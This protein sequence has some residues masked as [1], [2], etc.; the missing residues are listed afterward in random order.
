MQST[1][2]QSHRLYRHSPSRPC[3]RP[4]RAL[5]HASRSAPQPPASASQWRRLT[6]AHYSRLLLS[7]RS[8]R[9]TP[10][11]ARGACLSAV[12]TPCRCTSASCR[13]RFCCDTAQ[14]SRP[15][16]RS[17]CSYCRYFRC[18]LHHRTL[19]RFTHSLQHEHSP[20]WKQLKLNPTQ[21]AH[22]RC[23]PWLHQ[24]GFMPPPML[25]YPPSVRLHHS[26]LLRSNSPA[27]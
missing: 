25:S 12:T 13:V 27:F 10:T 7:P 22:E 5:P 11:P 4:C 17:Q 9:S 8:A 6:T 18:P 14:D 15:C 23:V 20:S 1:P 16:S 26:S 2:R 21:V 24:Y 3:C 19:I